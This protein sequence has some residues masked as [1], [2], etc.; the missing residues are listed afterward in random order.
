MEGLL[1]RP[2]VFLRS[3]VVPCVVKGELARSLAEE[4]S[5]AISD[6]VLV[7][8]RACVCL[9]FD[10]MKVDGSDFCFVNCCLPCHLSEEYVNATKRLK[11]QNLRGLMDPPILQ[12]FVRLS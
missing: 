5:F 1:R 11:K 7:G 2:D 6:P 12:T 4:Q 3:L 10:N 8:W 9:I